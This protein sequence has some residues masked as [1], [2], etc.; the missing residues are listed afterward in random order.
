MYFR[1]GNQASS[2]SKYSK[3]SPAA[4]LFPPLGGGEIDFFPCRGPECGGGNN[5][6][7]PPRGPDFGGV[8]KFPPPRG[9]DPGGGNTPKKIRLRRAIYKNVFLYS[10]CACFL[11][12]ISAKI[13][14][15]SPAAACMFTIVF[16][17]L[18]KFNSTVVIT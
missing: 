9:P 15:F 10:F 16:T 12:K 8:K 7:P 1:K 3:F 6:L 2:K 11:M 17:T 14:V 13:N 18:L 4:S 5:K